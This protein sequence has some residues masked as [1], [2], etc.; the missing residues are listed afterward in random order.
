MADGT[1]GGG[2]SAVLI[3]VLALTQLIGWGFSFDFLAVVGRP[4]ARDLDMANEIAFAGL[5]VMMVM[6]ALL[7]PVVG[8][9]LGRYGA[10]RVLAEGS[11]LFAVGLTALSA[12]V[13]P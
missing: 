10:A 5:S 4:V 2:G 13:G 11:V 12:S 7:G 3:G 9:R 6:A 1:R 8:A